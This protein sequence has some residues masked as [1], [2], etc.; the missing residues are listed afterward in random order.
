VLDALEQ[1]LHARERDRRLI[2]HS[3]RGSQYLSTRYTERLAQAGV[4][5]SE[6]SRGDSYDNAPAETIIGLYKTEVI[7]HLGLWR[8]A[9]DVEIATLEWVHWFN[10]QRL[11]EPIGD[12]PPAEFEQMNYRQ[13][14]QVAA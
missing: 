6:G 13:Q 7:H 8:G 12:I 1:A 11:L 3:D 2:V 10:H 14:G 9:T 4:A 5:A